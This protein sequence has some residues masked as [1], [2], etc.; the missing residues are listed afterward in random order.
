MTEGEDEHLG[1]SIQVGSTWIGRFEI[2]ETKESCCSGP[3]FFLHG[4]DMPILCFEAFGDFVHTGLVLVCQCSE[5]TALPEISQLVHISFDPLCQVVIVGQSSQF[6][7][8]C[9]Y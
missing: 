9:Q 1:K 6:R 3:V 2:F 5:Q 4:K 8:V 7:I